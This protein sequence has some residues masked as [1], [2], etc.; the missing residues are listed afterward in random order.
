MLT[1]APNPRSTFPP[2]VALPVCT[3]VTPACSVANCAQ[4][5][6]FSGVERTVD[7]FTFPPQH[8]EPWLIEAAGAVVLTSFCGSPGCITM[9]ITRSVPTPTVMAVQTCVVNPGL[10]I[11]T[12]YTAGG[13]AGKLYKPSVPVVASRVTVRA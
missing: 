4:S 11:V 1:G 9:L 6:P 13:R 5:R 2:P 7:E 12:S 8:A 3:P 10:E